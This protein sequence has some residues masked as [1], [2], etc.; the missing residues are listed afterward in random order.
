MISRLKFAHQIRTLCAVGLILAGGN[1]F[2]QP[3]SSPVL[4]HS[5][6][7]AGGGRSYGNGL[8]VD[9]SL[10]GFSEVHQTTPSGLRFQSG[11]IAA[12]NEPPGRMR[13]VFGPPNNLS[14]TIRISDLVG[15]GAD[16]EGD[17][18]TI[19]L[20]GTNTVRG[21]TVRQVGDAFV[22]TAPTQPHA[23]GND[24]FTYSM[25]DAFGGQE[26][27]TVLLT[28]TSYSG[29]PIEVRLLPTGLGMTFQGTASV[30]Y[31]L[32]FR[33]SIS[34]GG[35]WQD[36]PNW[37]SPLLD[38]ADALGTHRF[39]VDTS[40]RQGFFR[41]MAVEIPSLEPSIA[42]SGNQIAMT[43][44]GAPGIVYR[45]QSRARF[46]AVAQ[47]QDFP[48]DWQVVTQYAEW[49]GRVFFKTPFVAENRYFRVVPLLPRR[50]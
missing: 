49:D 12:L 28:A 40:L 29:K 20:T 42:R 15:N 9:T 13:S 50:I 27:G 47:W 32:Q 2:A 43:F 30:L 41:T 38:Q 25:T 48:S 21:G 10:A 34:P 7:D 1:A 35:S 19:S 36:F 45:L 6:L 8:I 39:T 18:V 17:P 33:T 4:V 14:G 5:T 23:D 22:Y 26:I 16:P 24:W 3:L 11:Y 46:D 37:F 31:K 44:S